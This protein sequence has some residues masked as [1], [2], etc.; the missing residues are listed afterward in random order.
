M[1]VTWIMAPSMTMLAERMLPISTAMSDTGRKICLN[2]S[3]S[4]GSLTMD[5]LQNSSPPGATPS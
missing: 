3:D 4:F 5:V 1:P 2:L